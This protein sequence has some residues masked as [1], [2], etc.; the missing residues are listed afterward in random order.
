MHTRQLSRIMSLSWQIQRQRG[1]TRSRSLMAAWAIF[2]NDEIVVH[3]LTRKHSS[4]YHAAKVL[5][6]RLT[7]FPC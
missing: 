1:A 5:P 4:Q 2:L 6:D 7:L 3:H